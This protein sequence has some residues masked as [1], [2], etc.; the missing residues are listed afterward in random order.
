[1]ALKHVIEKLEDVPEALREHYV[2]SDDG[3]YRLD[4]VEDVS[5]LKSALEKERKERAEAKAAL[6]RLK[7][8]DPDEYQ[9]L[10]KESE[11][12]E[13]D[14][15]MKKGEYDKLL[16]QVVE[17]HKGELDLK[18]QRIKSLTGSLESHL[19][20]AEATRA[21]AGAKG[22]PELLLPHVRASARVVEEDGKFVVKIVDKDGNPRI[23]DANGA[24]MSI[25]QLVGEMRQSEVFGRAF[26]ASGASG[27]GAPNGGRAGQG[28]SKTI[29]RVDFDA[30]GP[31][32]QR[33]HIKDG[34]T[35]TD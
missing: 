10:K 2:Q 17:K 21:I 11:D 12:R 29:K 25:A 22:V 34:G 4:G 27:S 18:E 20:D 26:E 30:L 8:I 32:E 33:A 9:R 24:P 35:I 23:G 19:I 1:M 3:K 6:Q 5:G 13:T 31:A 16:S 15:A 14:K 28:G 7:D